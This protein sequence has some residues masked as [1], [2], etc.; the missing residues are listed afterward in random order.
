MRWALVVAGVVL[1][2]VLLRATVFRPKA[3]EVQTA[4]AER[5]AVEDVV[6]NSQ[7]G[8][9]RAR[10]RSSLGAERAGRVTAIPFRESARV[11]RGAVLL[12]LDAS[13]ARTALDLARRERDVQR[14]HVESA[15][16]AYALAQIE[17]ERAESLRAQDVISQGEMDRIRTRFEEARAALAGAE[18]TAS[19]ADASVRLAE[20]DLAHMQVTAPYDG[21]I[22]Q[23]LVEVGESVVPGQPVIEVVSPESLYVS[24]RI[25]EVDIGRLR[26]GLPA[27]VTLDPYRGLTW[28]GQ[29]SRVFPVVD[30][31]LEQN[32]TLTVEVD[33]V[34]APD[35]PQPLPGTSADIVIVLDERKDV[36]RVPTF[37]VIEGRRVLVVENGRAVA[38]EVTTGLRNWEWTEITA[39]LEAGEPVITNLDKQGVRAG[40]AVEATPRE[41]A[42]AAP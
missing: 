30:D 31:R 11:R 7:A 9:V 33:I 35:R 23:R 36:L 27:R 38:R 22:A 20:D 18:A 4:I 10:R 2:I 15:R 12:Q 17:H 41:D 5:G 26:I 13:T 29:V 25:D 6:T 40:A 19:R 37:A 34:P 16:A 1:L 24:A 3:I 42:N 14:A 28:S 8:T 21:V 32:R 39:G